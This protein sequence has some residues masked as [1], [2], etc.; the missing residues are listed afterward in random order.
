MKTETNT[1][2]YLS[3]CLGAVILIPWVRASLKTRLPK[4]AVQEQI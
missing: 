4:P 1:I 2:G 3:I